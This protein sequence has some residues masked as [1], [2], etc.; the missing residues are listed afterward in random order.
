MIFLLA[1]DLWR[2]LCT[3]FS[4][5]QTLIITINVSSICFSACIRYGGYRRTETEVVD[6][7]Y[8]VKYVALVVPDDLTR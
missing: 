7:K 3:E 1:Y 4:G 8:G 6:V 5:T 2:L